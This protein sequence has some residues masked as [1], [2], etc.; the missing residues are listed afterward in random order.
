MSSIRKQL[1][2]D[3]WWSSKVRTWDEL[4]W[5]RFW[6]DSVLENLSK[7]S[8]SATLLVRAVHC[9]A[10]TGD[11]GQPTV[12]VILECEEGVYYRDSS[13]F[14]SQVQKMLDWGG[15]VEN[16]PPIMIEH[17]AQRFQRY[18]IFPLS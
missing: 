5:A 11:R 15:P 7:V 3:G 2:K 1:H 6:G 9:I 18:R 10:L 8:P 13:D 4:L 12:R 16:W 17:P 14:V